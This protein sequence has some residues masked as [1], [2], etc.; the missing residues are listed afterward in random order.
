MEVF[1][2]YK[3]LLTRRTPA[4]EPSPSPLAG[5]LLIAL[6]LAVLLVFA[7]WSVKVVTEAAD[8]QLE[9]D[10][11]S[12]WMRD[13][14]TAQRLLLTNH[15]DSP[16]VQT[17]FVSLEL[18]ADKAEATAERAAGTPT[19]ALQA[20]AQAL[21]GRV[22][23]LRATLHVPGE[24]DS[25]R[26][27]LIKAIDALAVAIWQ[28]NRR[29]AIDMGLQWVAIQRL[30]VAA[31]VLAG[32][33]LLMVQMARRRHLAAE[34]LSGQLERALVE[35]E[36]ARA[37][38]WQASRAKSEFLATV[39]HEIRTPMTAILGT[40]ELLG[41]TE[42]DS[43]QRDCVA[44]IHSGGQALLNI[45]ND[46]LDLSRMEAER[47]ELEEEPFE[48]HELLDAV[49]LLFAG[50]AE[51]KGLDLGLVQSASLPLVAQGDATRLRQ[52]L[53]N[54]VGNAIK[55]T[56]AGHVTIRAGTDA[57]GWTQVEV[58]D[59][60][61]GLP[62]GAEHHIFEAFSQ[63][64]SSTSRQ[65]GGT[66]LGL[67]ICRRLVE[68]MGGVLGVEST[69][70]EGARFWF[71]V[72]LKVVAEATSVER[73]GPTL[74]VGADTP[75]ALAAEQL[76]AWNIKVV[77]AATAAEAEQAIRWR[78]FDLV[79]LG[80]GVALTERY[81]DLYIARMVPFSEGK[82]VPMIERGEVCAMPMR[83]RRL[84]RLLGDD[85]PSIPPM[86]LDTDVTGALRPRVLVVDDNAT[87]RL[88]VGQLLG[89]LGCDV[90]QA[91][92]GRVALEKTADQVYD[93]VFMDFDMPEMD[94]L[95]TTERLRAGGGPSARTPV[96][97]LTGHATEGAR[98]S[99]LAAGMNDYLPKPVRLAQLKQVLERWVPQ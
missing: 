50:A 45:I 59:T 30:A 22:Q 64:D 31:I 41:L 40:V 63:V 52:V 19:A 53:V 84:Q 47:L 6:G 38:A 91:D 72:P 62:P 2:G 97:G 66:G 46:V 16:G 1:C 80:R 90:E 74:V 54:L 70:G 48:L 44:V 95:T 78:R 49:V 12:H 73:G 8:L 77:T 87:N 28:D 25:A 99:G 83:P 93:L 18:V 13:L 23:D 27:E 39:S 9:A 7:L 82:S 98:Q 67:A 37:E 26:V 69:L 79:L 65:H 20:P 57:R 55:F 51:A 85:A 43:R 68:A 75:C 76:R 94:G 3:T 58:Q 89:A 29:I 14:Q 5:S 88:V 60:G 92:G 34:A 17:A 11:R 36:Q 21:R 86:D 42:L 15:P 96:V 32:L 24:R 4:P 33:A 71:A 56:S 35:A 61:P 10:A 81:P